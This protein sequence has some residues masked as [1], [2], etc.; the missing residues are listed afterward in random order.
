M[1]KTRRNGLGALLLAA[2]FVAALWPA[3]AGAQDQPAPQDKPQAKAQAPVPAR[4]RDMIKDLGITPEQQKQIREFR[5]ARMKDRQAFRDEMMKMRTEMRD[6]AKDP[7]ANAA[8]IDGLIDSTSKL[9]A[10]HE[11]AAFRAR[12]EF[13][14]VFTPEQLQ[15]MKALRGAFA[16][17]AGFFRPGMGRFMGPR[18][19][20]GMGP[21][22]GPRAFRGW[23]MRAAAWRW[24]HPFFWYR[25]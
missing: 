18:G 22:F 19:G 8:R 4:P 10:D 25:F 21:G 15:K 24:R 11:K 1:N 6:L 12:G 3:A 16:G 14:K 2:A 17:R 23:R 5:E 20:W 13:E 7:K 9:R